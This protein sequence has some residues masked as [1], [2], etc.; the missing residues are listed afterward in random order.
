MPFAEH[1]RSDVSWRFPTPKAI[2]YLHQRSLPA[3][4]IAVQDFHGHVGKLLV[5]A[6][7]DLLRAEA[8]GLQHLPL[9][10]CALP[11]DGFAR[12]AVVADQQSF[13]AMDRQRH[14]AVAATELMS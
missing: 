9:T 2:Q 11:G 13:P 3:G 1:L 8:D 10:E 7:L 14:R 5:E 6:L 4:G 12:A